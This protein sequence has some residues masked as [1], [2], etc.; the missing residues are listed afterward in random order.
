[1]HGELPASEALAVK[2]RERGASATVAR[3]GLQIDLSS[4]AVLA[5]DS[6]TP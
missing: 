5:R 6:P 4:L 3:P 2:L 1:V